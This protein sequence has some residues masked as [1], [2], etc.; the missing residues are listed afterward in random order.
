MEI[1]QLFYL[2][3]VYNCKYVF[4]RRQATSTDDYVSKVAERH[5]SLIL[6]LIKDILSIN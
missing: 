4:I 2:L 6:K 5:L 3:L 1:R